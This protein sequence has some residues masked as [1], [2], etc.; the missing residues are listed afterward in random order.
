VKREI[1]PDL[2]VEAI[3]I[4]TKKAKLLQDRLEFWGQI[5]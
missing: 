2:R 1:D 3:D 4:K 5:I